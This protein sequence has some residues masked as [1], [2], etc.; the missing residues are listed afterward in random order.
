MFCTE[1]GKEIV[2]TAKFCSFCGL[3]V[4]NVV[5]RAA[6][7]SPTPAP[8]YEVPVPQSPA[9][10]APAA[11]APLEEAPAEEAV[12]VENIFGESG[13]VEAPAWDNSAAEIPVFESAPETNEP[14]AAAVSAPENYSVP[15]LPTPNNI[16]TSG[17]S[18]GANAAG[19]I[20]PAAMVAEKAPI[21]RPERK[22]TFGH[23]M[24]CLAAVAIMAITAGVFAGLYFSVV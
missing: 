5:V 8:V 1:C 22:Y 6:A 7:P 17:E 14:E 12:A 20:P 2:D 15:L 21:E 18:T 24:M 13:T 4:Q 16:P 11:E 9:P 19:A 10:E 3:P 23:I